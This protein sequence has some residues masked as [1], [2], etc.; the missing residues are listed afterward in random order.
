MNTLLLLAML[1]AAPDTMVVRV[2]LPAQDPAPAPVV[3]VEVH[4]DSL[5]AAYERGAAASERAV[6]LAVAGSGE[7]CGCGAPG[8]FYAGVL[9]LGT[10]AVS[11]LVYHVYQ[12][13]RSGDD[14]DETPKPE[15]HPHGHKPGRG[16]P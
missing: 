11:A 12:F 14:W 15:R 2:P 6:A 3:H 5:A 10:V 16:K 8:W 9:T 7:S 13:H 1:Q 4:T